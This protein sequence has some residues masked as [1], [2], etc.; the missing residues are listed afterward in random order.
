M[1]KPAKGSLFLLA[2]IVLVGLNL[3]PALAAIGPLL[4]VI[5]RAIVLT[6]TSA[7][8]LTTIPVVLMG[9]CSLGAYH[10]RRLID[11]RLGI[12]LAVGAIAT[13][14]AARGG[15]SNGDGLIGTAVVAGAGIGIVQALLPGFIRRCFGRGAG[16]IMGYYSTAIMGG[17]MLASVLSPRLAKHYGWNDALSIWSLPAVFAAGLWIWATR[18]VGARADVSEAVHMPFSRSPRAW[19]L[20]LFFGLGTG[21]YTLVLAWLPPYYTALGWTPSVAGGL[22][23]VLTLAEIAAGFMV[24]FWIDRLPDRRPALLAAVGMLFVGLIC[25]IITPTSLALPA[26]VLMGLGIGALF[27]LS[28]IVAMDHVSDSQQAGDLVAFVQGGGYLLAALFP[29]IA[30]LLRQHMADLTPAW[31][32]MVVISVMLAG[33]ALRFSPVSYPRL[34]R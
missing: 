29:F 22:L 31:I 15:A 2:T 4:D 20:T 26:V 11:I 33:I 30:G 16:G 19:L 9:A 28:L 12:L 3:R 34:F 24:S 27:P 18:S 23:G 8:L 1:S 5:Q 14:C 13:A 21:G 17:A 10:L 25:L 6:D 32:L 7:S